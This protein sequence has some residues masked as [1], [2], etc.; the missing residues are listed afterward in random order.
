[1]A[2]WALRHPQGALIIALL[3]G[4]V[5][6]LWGYVQHAD[7]FRITQVQ[8]PAQSTL[9]VPVSLI[10]DNLW[11][12]DIRTL[13][14]ALNRQQPWLKEVRVTRQLPNTVRIETIPRLPVA[15]VQLRLWY[16]VDAE[17]FVIPQPSAAPAEQWP[18]VVG[19]ERAQSSIKIG[20]VNTDERLKTALRV[21]KTLK[22][23]PALTSHR[24]TDV[25]VAD[26]QQLRFVIDGEIEIRCGS[27]ADLGGQLEQLRSVMRVIATKP[28]DVRYIDVRFKEPVVGPRTPS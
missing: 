23:T 5:W 27:E 4:T 7:A 12:L 14:E 6:G 25:D 22:Y 11:A 15:Q 19:L 17:G 10:G 28:V 13:A 2:R 24:V 8:L 26:L 20:A 16:P 18:R 1:M 21:L 3:V 9:K